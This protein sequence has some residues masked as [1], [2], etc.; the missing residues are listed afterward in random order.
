MSNQDIWRTTFSLYQ[1]YMSLSRYL[2]M[3]VF[4]HRRKRTVE[5]AFCI[6]ECPISSALSTPCSH[7][8]CHSCVTRNVEVCTR[9]ET[10]YPPNCCGN[11]FPSRDLIN[12]LEDSSLKAKYKTKCIEYSM[13]LADRIYCYKCTDFLGSKWTGASSSSSLF[14]SIFKFASSSTSTRSVAHETLHC[15]RCL[16]NT[17]TACG[18]VHPSGG[19]PEREDFAFQQLFAERKWQKCPN[20]KA[21]VER[22]SGCYSIMCRCVTKFCYLCGKKWKGCHCPV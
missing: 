21:V 14:S 4:V 9:D 17:C 6:E 12:L 8:I 19:C 1:F 10:T 5:C 15:R 16:V 11:R 20:C 13:P 3:M 2:H 22:I 18:V 7:Y